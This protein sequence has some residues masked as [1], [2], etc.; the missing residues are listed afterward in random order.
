MEKKLR[1]S[2]VKPV[3]KP[4][5]PSP[6]T[7]LESLSGSDALSILKILADRDERLAGEID[8][9][10][11]EQKM[12]RSNTPAAN[13][14]RSKSMARITDRRSRRASPGGATKRRTISSFR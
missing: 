3:V 7:L 10:A 13:S 2:A 12:G 11:G 14:L 4:K 9:V 1:K 5:A 8:A 6:S